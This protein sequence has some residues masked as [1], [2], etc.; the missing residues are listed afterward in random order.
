VAR[1]LPF[2]GVT[3]P[4]HWID[5]GQTSD[6]WEAVQRVMRGELAFVELPGKELAPGVRG[7]VNLDVD[8]A[9]TDIR[10]PVYLGSSTRIEP[11]AVIEGP[12][13][14]G[15]NCV[16]E[17]GARI[18]A[19]IV[20]NYTRVSGL[21]DLSERVVSGRFCVDRYGRNVDLAGTGYAF[22]VDDARERR[23]WTDDQRALIEF[24]RLH[25]VAAE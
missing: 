12:T 20:G 7:G 24:L 17:A 22:V 16:V 21:A 19:T 11:G 23:Q 6:Y 4:F 3:L 8:F 25:A 10:G 15:R 18:R 14:I 1:G 9:S 2:Y 5:I 13:V